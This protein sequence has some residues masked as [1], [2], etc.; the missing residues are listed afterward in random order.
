MK[1]LYLLRG[2]PGSG[3]STLAESLD[4]YWFETDFY[5]IRDGKYEF[6]V[7]KLKEAHEWCQ[8]NTEVSMISAGGDIIVSNTFTQEWEM[9]PYIEMATKHGYR[10]VTLIVENRHGGESIHGVPE[11]TMVKMKD[12][13]EI[14]L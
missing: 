2:L 14:S 6:D 9:E 10:V 7:S 4:G 3:K 5:F 8:D 13:F 1:T 12:R 11:E